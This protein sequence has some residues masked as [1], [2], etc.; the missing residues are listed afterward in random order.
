MPFRIVR[1]D[2]TKIQADAIVNTANPDPVLGRGTDCEGYMSAVKEKLFKE[3][4]KIG[5]I[6]PGKAAVTSK[7]V[8]SPKYNRH[9]VVPF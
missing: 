1:D 2:L 8:L 7:C 6:L 3:R 5:Y 4:Q 9:T